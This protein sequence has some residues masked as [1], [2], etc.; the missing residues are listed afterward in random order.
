MEKG[1]GIQHHI[2]ALCQRYG[3]QSDLENLSCVS[4]VSALPVCFVNPKYPKWCLSL[5][6]SCGRKWYCCR[7]CAETGKFH[8]TQ[9]LEIHELIHQPDQ[10]DDD[11]ESAAA[12]TDDDEDALKEKLSALFAGNDKWTQFLMHHRNGTALRYLVAHQFSDCLECGDV[13]DSDAELHILIA[14]HAHSLTKGERAQFADILGRIYKKGKSARLSTALEIPIPTTPLEINRYLDGSRAIMTNI[15]APKIHTAENGDAYVRLKDIIKL[16]YSF[17]LHATTVKLISET[18]PV[19]REGVS[20]NMWQTP[21]ARKRLQSLGQRTANS[22][23][24]ALLNWSD[25]CDANTN[26]NNRGSMHVGTVTVYSEQNSNNAENTFVLHIGREDVHHHE[27]TRI[28]LE[29][30]RELEIPQFLYNGNEFV[31]AQFTDIASIH[32]RPDRSKMCGFGSHNGTFSIRFPFSSPVPETLVSCDPCRQRRERCKSSWKSNHACPDCYDWDFQDII[33]EP[34]EDFPEEET[35]ESGYLSAKQLTFEDL[36]EAAEKT[37]NMVVSKRWKKKTAAAYLRTMSINNEIAT[38]I[39]NN[40]RSEAPESLDEIV[41]PVWLVA[42]NTDRF[43]EAVMHMLFLGVTKTVGMMLRDLLTLYGRWTPFYKTTQPYLR[44]LRNYSLHYCRI[45]T[46]GSHEKPFSPWFSENHLAYARCFKMV[47]NNVSVLLGGKNEEERE[48]I[49]R[50]AKKTISTWSACISRVM[51][52]PN[53][54]ENTNSA[55]RHIKLFLSAVNALD[56]AI[57]D[58]KKRKEG[59][60]EQEKMRIQT[61][62]NF[63]GLL[64]IPNQMRQFGNLR[65]YWEGSFR[66]ERILQELKPLVSQGTYHPWFARNALSKFYKSRTMSL[67]LSANKTVRDDTNQHGNAYTMYYRYENEESVQQFMLEGMPLSGVILN[68]GRIFAACGR[69]RVLRFLEIDVD[70]NNGKFIERTFYSLLSTGEE[71]KDDEAVQEIQQQIADYVLMLPYSDPAASRNKSNDE[72]DD[73]T[74]DNIYFYIVDT[75]WRERVC[76]EDGTYFSFPRLEN[77][78]Y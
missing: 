12:P 11:D 24:I 29:D 59:A 41:P 5:V 40:A 36:K 65:D 30:L 18:G 39:I 76:N 8:R 15:P 64:N 3:I 2:G 44:V 77:V 35:N 25:G 63:V 46:F 21:Q 49:W 4:C 31:N 23:K 74:D 6:C 34:P 56:E 19:G 71:V 47:G 61:V 48:R 78:N 43:V 51:L 1:T 45:W 37:H 22:V 73:E 69:N 32:D 42:D 60:K 66:G 9:Q 26:K 57:I 55:E 20:N 67:L 38:K 13:T 17:G 54:K 72:T 52:K 75:Q 28:L 27:V 33:F 10:P 68:D 53:D 14:S 50:I 16:Y 62:S 58:K 70:D 7:A